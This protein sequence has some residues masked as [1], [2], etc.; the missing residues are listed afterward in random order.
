[1]VEFETTGR[2]RK[3]PK[4]RTILNIDAHVLP[5]TRNPAVLL[6]HR[7]SHTRARCT[8]PGRIPRCLLGICHRRGATSV[9]CHRRLSPRM[10]H[11]QYAGRRSL[12]RRAVTTALKRGGLA[13]S[14]L[15]SRRL[16]MR[17]RLWRS[18]CAD[19]FC[20][21]SVARR[22][23]ESRHCGCQHL[24]GATGAEARTLAGLALQ[25]DRHQG[26]RSRSEDD[27]AISVKARQRRGVDSG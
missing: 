15:S 21:H 9:D 27:R 4:A 18:P 11:A 6:C 8:L 20:R 2:V 24:V 12:D 7:R 19:L 26:E 3:T 10:S 23:K 1:M 5:P 13:A 17:R 22:C 16:H 25:V 14:R